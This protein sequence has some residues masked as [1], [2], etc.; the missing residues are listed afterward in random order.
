MHKHKMKADR[1][2]F[3]NRTLYF[4]CVEC[5]EDLRITRGNY[6]K[7]FVKQRNPRNQKNFIRRFK[8]GGSLVLELASPNDPERFFE[9]LFGYD[10][11]YYG[12]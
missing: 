4:E 5:G 7:M 12:R 11:V 10:A 9:E 8:Q 3:T 6:R 1:T 2:K